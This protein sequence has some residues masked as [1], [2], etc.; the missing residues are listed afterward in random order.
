[1][2][3]RTVRRDTVKPDMQ[4]LTCYEANRSRFG[5]RSVKR[6]TARLGKEPLTFCEV[7]ST[8]FV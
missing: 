1:M 5:V 8:R 4:S 2:R 7:N 6:D 3:V